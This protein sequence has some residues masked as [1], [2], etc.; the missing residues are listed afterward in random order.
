MGTANDRGISLRA[1]A[2][3]GWLACI[4]KSVILDILNFPYL[5]QI[6]FFD[7]PANFPSWIAFC[8]GRFLLFCPSTTTSTTKFFFFFLLAMAFEL[9]SFWKTFSASFVRFKLGHWLLAMARRGL[10]ARLGPGIGS[11]G[12]KHFFP[13]KGS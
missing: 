3:S 6:V 12:P 4:W 9:V 1:S 5:Y 13:R 11:F 10:V 8:I 2:S 7:N